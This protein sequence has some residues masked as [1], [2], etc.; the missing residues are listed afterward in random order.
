LL[1]YEVSGKVVLQ[2]AIRKG[3]NSAAGV[4]SGIQYVFAPRMV[5]RA[6]IDSSTGSFLFGSGLKLK[7]CWIQLTISRHPQ[8]GCTPG[9]MLTYHLPGK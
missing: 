7:L 6:G 1:A 9:L 4:V 5:A 3:E 8:L 2:T